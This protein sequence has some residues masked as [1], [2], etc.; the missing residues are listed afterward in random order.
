MEKQFENAEMRVV[1]NGSLFMATTIE[2]YIAVQDVQ[3]L[4]LKEWN[5]EEK[6]KKGRVNNMAGHIERRGE[7][8]FRLI[9]SSGTAPD[10]KRIVYKKTIKV[11]PAMTESK[12]I[13]E[14]EKALAAFITEI[15]LGEY[16]KP[17]TL[18]FDDLF[19]K[20]IAS[21]QGDKRLAPKTEARY[22]EMYNLRIK[23]YF[24]KYKPE[25]ID[26]DVL[27][28]FFINLRKKS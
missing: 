4:K 11:S 12:K 10:G 2:K 26:A 13:K 17:T 5:E 19:E 25:N 23:N 24:N 16:K 1:V 20:W 28:E 9:V 6:R 8:S 14:A 3:I 15:E 27:D 18:S 7:N 22:R 21:H